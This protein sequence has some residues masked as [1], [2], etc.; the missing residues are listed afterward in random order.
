MSSSEQEIKRL[1]REIESLEAKL[2]AQQ[3]PSHSSSLILTTKQHSE[4]LVVPS[5]SKYQNIPKS[6]AG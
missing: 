3:A 6:R 4:Q 1:R 5:K 2:K